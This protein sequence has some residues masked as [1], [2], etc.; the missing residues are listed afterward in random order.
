MERF[1]NQHCSKFSQTYVL[2]LNGER[3]MHRSKKEGIINHEFLF[4]I[5]YKCIRLE[6][7][8]ISYLYTYVFSSVCV[9]LYP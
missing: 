1:K 9:C 8:E 6:K 5:I 3:E 4:I 2:L 7:T